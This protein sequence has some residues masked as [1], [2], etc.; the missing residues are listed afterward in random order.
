MTSGGDSG[1]R[2]LHT[3]AVIGGL[4]V[5]GKGRFKGSFVQAAFLVL[6]AAATRTRVVAT[7]FG[8]YPD[9]L[10]LRQRVLPFKGLLAP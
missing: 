7:G 4:L 9:I 1:P 2:P 10:G 8:P 5:F 3:P 6:S